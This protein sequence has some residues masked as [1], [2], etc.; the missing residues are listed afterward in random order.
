MKKNIEE[1]LNRLN[2]AEA[3]R[4]EKQSRLRT[5]FASAKQKAI[6]IDEAL[7]TAE[8]PDEYK[9]LLREKNEN[10]SFL[11]FLT[12]RKPNGFKPAISKN[13]YR[14]I[15]DTCNSEIKTLQEEYAPRVQKEI[16]KLTSL[17]DEYSKEAEELESIKSKASL[18]FNNSNS[19]TYT[20][21]DLKDL[22][23]DP[24]FYFYHICK[25]YFNHRATI[26]RLKLAVSKDNHRI[27]TGFTTEEA[28][29]FKEL[30]RRAS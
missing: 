8:D 24:L 28:R 23:I 27:N 9:K 29:I 18:L 25:A 16:E 13:E 1:I 15:I 4:N 22:D 17:L 10:E 26:K 19:A 2:N 3:S 12:A 14:D 20:A 5:E 11:E 7:K 6:D 30:S 21:N